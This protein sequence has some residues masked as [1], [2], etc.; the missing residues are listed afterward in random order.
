MNN[1]SKLGRRLGLIAACALMLGAGFSVRAAEPQPNIL[2][3]LAD[4]LGYGD[5]GAYGHPHI[6][7]PHL[8]KLAAEG[9]LM[10]DCYAAA[11]V[12]SPARAGLLTG[13]APNRTG[14]YD[15]IPAHHAAHLRR[16]EITAATLL[17]QAGYDTAHVGKW[18]LNGKFNSPEQ[19]QPHDH[20]F[21]YWLATQ[22]NAAPSHKNP[23]NF[24]RNGLEVGPLEGFAA[25]LVAREGA[26]WL[27]NRKDA[28]NPF[29]LQV[30]FHEPHEPVASPPELVEKY[31]DL[32]RNEDEAQYFANVENMDRAIGELLRALDELGVAENT[33]VF[34]TSDNGPETLRRYGGATRSYGSPGPLREM[35]LH[36]YE[37]GIRVPG[38]LRWPARIQAG[39]VSA[40][41]VSGVDLLPTVCEL[42]GAV[43]P[44][45]RPIDGA[46]FVSIFSGQPIK[47]AA[48]LFWTYYRALSAP[49][50]A[51]R[52][53]DWK[54]V[55]HW[56]G[57]EGPIGGNVNPQSMH[58]IKTASLTDFE[59]YN[60]REDIAETRDLS[61]AEP[62]RLKTLSRQLID[63]YTEAQAEGF[64]WT[65]PAEEP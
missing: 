35:K 33:L 19:P 14:V 8:D 55:A 32:A 52:D 51:L 59:L 10:T 54:L 1:S 25:N 53:G 9:L 26:Q 44:A 17:K 36:L 20:G 21:D 63:L 6:Q 12:C 22:N 40:E 13:R 23:Q 65:F 61:A 27:R 18:H 2:V 47:R 29:Y 37:G 43:P 57:P 24:A 58:L 39:Q 45:D 34:F 41:P 30:W 56:D 42:A 49:K 64:E 60:L 11:P 28:A 31:R 7:T 46:S 50:A 15:W 3:I 38:I 5:L 48:P 16:E 62:K 4:D